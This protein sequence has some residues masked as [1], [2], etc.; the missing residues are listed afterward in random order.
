MHIIEGAVGAGKTTYAIQLGREV[1][2]PPLVLDEWMVNL[3]QPDRP[4]SDLWAWYA[5]RKAR[6]IIQIME[7]ARRALDHERHAIVELGLVRGEDRHR[8]YTD[9]DAEGRDYLVHVL[10]TPRDERKRRVLQRNT[11]QGAPFAMH[12][13]E[14]VFEIAS[15]MWEPITSTEVLG[16]EARFHMVLEDRRP[17]S[18]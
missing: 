8:L 15:N 12:V 14:E 10:E 6:C 1:G 13:T 9:L 11:E 3:F 16:R 5:E 2:S 18:A 4:A 7:L 17:D